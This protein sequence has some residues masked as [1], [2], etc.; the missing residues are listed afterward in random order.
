MQATA[1]TLREQQKTAW[2]KFSPGWNKWDNMIMNWMKPVADKLVASGAPPKGGMVLDVAT[3]TGEPGLSI[4][5]K[6][7]DCTVIGMD[8]SED[9]LKVAVRKAEEMGVKNY[10]TKS[11]NESALPFPENTF[12]VIVSRFGVI[13]FP[14]LEA[15]LKNLV[16]VLKPGGKIS[17]A[18]WGPKEKNPWA[19]VSA[20]AVMQEL[21]LTPPPPEAPGIFRCEKVGLVP[22][23][24]KSLGLKNVEEV[25]VTGINP[26]ASAEEYWSIMVDIAAPIAMALKDKDEATINRVREKVI[27]SCEPFKNDGKVVF[28]FTAY[29]TSAVK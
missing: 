23:I 15:G 4:A 9:M 10:S 29:V 27:S 13:F 26:F 11:G 25:E 12:D 22:G 14:E 24:L 3:G 2:N 18:V 7:P 6:Y 1:Q 21:Q 5:A 19:T 8:I 16:K 20:Q 28:P 17:V